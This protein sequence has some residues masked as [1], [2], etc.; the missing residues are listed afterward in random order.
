MGTA[1][2][3]TRGRL[4]AAADSRFRRFGFRHSSVEAITRAAGT[5]KGSLYLHF[6]S[7]EALYLDVVGHAV[8]G[9]V[10]EATSAMTEV[11]TAPARLRALVETAIDYYGNDDL[12]CAILIGD[13][14]LV[15]GPVARL[16][17]DLQ[18]DRITQLIEHTIEVGQQEGTLRQGLDPKASAT[19]LYEIGWAIVRRHLEGRLALPLG[20]ALS[21]LNDI[22]GRGTMERV[23]RAEAS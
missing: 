14:D 10:N 17:D 23:D 19:V 6:S 13:D 4:L 21:T 20:E 1:E 11:E 16:A 12:L 9:F 7:K 5:G 22:V 2:T 8:T 18:R 15:T 3:S